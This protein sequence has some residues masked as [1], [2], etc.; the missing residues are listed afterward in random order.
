MKI[1]VIGQGGHSK[2]I[3]D[4]LLSNDEYEIVGYLDDKYEEIKVQENVFYGPV[5]SAKTM[6]EYFTDIK[7]IIAIGDNLIRKSIAEKLELPDECYATLIDKSAVVSPHAAI[8]CGT[9]VMPNAVI[10]ADS[11]I[12]KHAIIN[13][14]SVVEHDCKIAD[15]VHISP[16]AALTGGVQIEEG[17]SVGAGAAVIPNVTVCDWTVIGA[18]ATVITD[19]P[20]HCTAVGTP[21]RVKNKLEVK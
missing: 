7:F 2:V 8:G 3:S 18:G 17:V 11:K 1:V 5:I 4:M 16:H 9:V 6:V 15:F 12:G 19:I 20:S 14:G 10:N 21:A 13:T